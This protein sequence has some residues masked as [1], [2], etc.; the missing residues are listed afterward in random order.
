MGQWISTSSKWVTVLGF[1]K[2]SSA[3]EGQNCKSLWW[4]SGRDRCGDSV[5]LWK[6]SLFNQVDIYFQQ[7]LVSS[8]GTN[9]AYKSYMDVLLNFSEDTERSQIQTQLFYKDSAGAFD[10]TKVKELPL[11]QGLIIRQKLAKNSHLVDM[12]GPILQIHLTCQDICEMR[13]M[14]A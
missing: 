1:A 10:Q 9:Y 13:W 5:N 14:C 3:C 6:Q 12:C 2:K 7:K 4:Q 8:S 11:N